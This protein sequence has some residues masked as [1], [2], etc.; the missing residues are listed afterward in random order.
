MKPGCSKSIHARPGAVT[1]VVAWSWGVGT[2]GWGTVD[3]IVR[4]FI[5]YGDFVVER[6]SLTSGSSH[7]GQPLEPSDADADVTLRRDPSPDASPA[8]RKP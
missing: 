8:R 4:G 2:L 1:G 6:G 5:C 3:R 7:P